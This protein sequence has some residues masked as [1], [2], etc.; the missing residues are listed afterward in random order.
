MDRAGTPVDGPSAVPSSALTTSDGIRPTRNEI[1]TYYDEK[2]ARILDKYGPGPKVHYHTGLVDR[3]SVVPHAQSD[4]RRTMRSAQEA[5]LV[6]MADSL[7]DRGRGVRLLD[8]GCG[9]GGGSIFWAERGAQVTAITIAARHVD[10]V[11]GFAR[12]AGVGG[13]LDVLCADAHTLPGEALYDAAVAVESSSYLDRAVWLRRVGRLLR[14][15]GTVHVFDWMVPRP[16]AAPGV[17]AHWK[18][19]MGTPTEY[20]T[21]GRAGGLRIAAYEILNDRTSDFWVLARRWNEMAL[22][23]PDLPPP[24]RARLERSTTELSALEA[25]F[26]EGSVLSVHM[27]LEQMG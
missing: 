26:R 18:T 1:A 22:A 15:G 23:A 27:V 7:P 3:A 17:D 16:G 10:L 9:L 20:E 19:R 21:Q 14:R 8:V 4:L 6:Y 25:A 11:R 13:R 2:T 5:V 24:E 12:E